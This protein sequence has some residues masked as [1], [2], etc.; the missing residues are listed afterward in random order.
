MSQARHR[1]GPGDPTDGSASSPAGYRSLQP[2]SSGSRATQ[3]TGSGRD[4]R[5][6]HSLPPPDRAPRNTAPTIPEN[7]L[8]MRQNRPGG[9]LSEEEGWSE[10]AQRSGH[11]STGA[12]SGPSPRAALRT[13]AAVTQ[14]REDSE[15]TFRLA[16]KKPTPGW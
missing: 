1:G 4:S 9:D 11:T 2:S 5:P 10:A 13:G 12:A 6:R 7:A 14:L 16:G 3:A 8:Q 15:A